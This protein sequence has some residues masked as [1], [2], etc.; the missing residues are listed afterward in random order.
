M[1]DPNV[2]LVTINGYDE[3][4]LPASFNPKTIHHVLYEMY[5]CARSRF[6]RR[7]KEEKCECSHVRAIQHHFGIQAI[8]IRGYRWRKSRSSGSR[9]S[10]NLTNLHFA[11][12]QQNPRALTAT[13]RE[14]PQ[15]I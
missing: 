11:E 6:T 8:Y 7:R 10:M 9:T 4:M 14:R 5:D 2:Q 12:Y 1:M 13:I 15:L 3:R